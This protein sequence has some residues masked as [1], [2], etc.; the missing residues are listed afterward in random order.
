MYFVLPSDFFAPGGRFLVSF[1]MRGLTQPLSR[2]LAET[3]QG[4]DSSIPFL[5]QLSPWDL[6]WE[7]AARATRFP[8]YLFFL[9]GPSGDLQIL[10]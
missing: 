1:I 9:P 7:A 5:P 3:S 4:A 10:L 2:A 8:S 6:W